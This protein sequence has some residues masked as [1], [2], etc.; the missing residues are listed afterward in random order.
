[1]A[2]VVDLEPVG[3]GIRSERY[4][5]YDKPEDQTE[6]GDPDGPLPCPETAPDR[7]CPRVD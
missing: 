2:L 5:L 6:I 3:G 1:M 4:L 7:L